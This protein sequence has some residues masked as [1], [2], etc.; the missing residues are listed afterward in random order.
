LNHAPVLDT[1][2]SSTLPPVNQSAGENPGSLIAT[3]AGNRITDADSTAQRGIAVIRADN[4]FGNWQFSTDNGVTWLAVADT[5]IGGASVWSS[6]LLLADAQTRIR[7]VPLAGWHGTAEMNYRAWDQ[8]DGRANGGLSATG[9]TGGTSPFSTATESV[10]VSVVPPVGLSSEVV[11]EHA[12]LG[13]VVGSLFM[14]GNSASGSTYRLVSGPGDTG[15]RLFTIVGNQLRTAS[16]TFDYST[17]PWTYTFRVQATA[18]GGTTTEQVVR[19]YVANDNQAPT[20]ILLS[21]ATLAESSPAGTTVATLGV[22]DPDT[23]DRFSY[24][25]VSGAGSDDNASFVIRN[26]LLTSNVSFDH[27]R[28]DTYR[29]RVRATDQG[30]LWVEQAFVLTVL[31]NGPTTNLTPYRVFTWNYPEQESSYVLHTWNDGIDPGA[32]NTYWRRP[33]LAAKAFLAFPA[34][35]RALLVQPADLLPDGTAITSH[36]ADAIYDPAQDADAGAVAYWGPW[37]SHG[38]QAA[39]E[40]VTHYFQTLK[41]GGL[42]SL[43][44]LMLDWEGYSLSFW[45]AVASPAGRIRAIRADPRYAEFAAQFEAAFPEMFPPGEHFDLNVFWAD[46][47]WRLQGQQGLQALYYWSSFMQSWYDRALNDAIYEAARSVF[48]GVVCGNFGVSGSSVA[49]AVQ[50][51][52][53]WPQMAINGMWADITAP[54]LYDD[55]GRLGLGEV[56]NDPYRNF[57]LIVNATRS[58][59]RQYPNLPVIPWLA[60]RSYTAGN[61]S[62]VPVANTDYWQEMLIHTM[63]STGSTNAFCFNST[64]VSTTGTHWTYDADV[65]AFESVL[66]SLEQLAPRGFYRDHPLDLL[67]YADGFSVSYATTDT[68]RIVG[69]VTFNSATSRATFRVGSLSLTVDRGAGIPA[70]D[71]LP[72]GQFFVIDPPAAVG[73]TYHLAQGSTLVISAAG[74]LANDADPAGRPLQAAIVSHPAHGALSLAADGSFTYTPNAGFWGSD[75]FTYQATNGAA[76]SPAVPV[77]VAVRPQLRLAMA[78]PSDGF[79]GVPGQPRTFTLSILDGGASGQI[80]PFNYRIRWGD[81]SEQVVAGDAT[82]VSHAFVSSGSFTPWVVAESVDGPLSEAMAGPR[83]VITALENQGPNLAVGGAANAD[84]FRLAQLATPGSFSVSVNASSYGTRAVSGAGRILVFGDANDRLTIT[85]TSRVDSFLLTTDAV[86][87]NGV[88]VQVLGGQS[89]VLDGYA[90]TDTLVG[91]D[92]NNT[93]QLTGSLS[94]TLNSLIAFKGIEN[95]SGGSRDDRFQLAGTSTGIRIDG[96]EGNNTLDYGAV[97]AAIAINVGTSTANLITRFYNIQAFVGGLNGRS[98]L[99]SGAGTNTWILDGPG[100]GSLNGAR[101]SGF[102]DLIG[103]TGSDTISVRNAGRL[104]GTVDGGGGADVLDYSLYTRGGV[105]IDLR[106]GTASAIAQARNIRVVVGTS[107]ADTLIAGS[108][109][110]VLIGDAGDDTLTGGSAR[111]LLIG[112]QGD[113]RLTAT[114]GETILFGGRT[115]YYNEETK[116]LDVSAIDTILQQWGKAVAYASRIASLWPTWVNAT[117]FLAERNARD[118]LFGGAAQDWYLT[119]AGNTAPTAKSNETVTFL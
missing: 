38:L 21:A 80:A 106:A 45:P 64:L 118:Q 16:T 105:R 2:G 113:D 7:F 115:V 117:T 97:N 10:T 55:I 110:T 36:P 34:G 56:W 50:Q 83:L 14:D 102:R 85:G 119:P 37:F 5:Y 84:E 53:N 3:I 18:P 88:T 57:Q 87:L 59:V 58:S 43:D 109:P 6:R 46:G 15:N 72:L 1:S 25:L 78:G 61:P 99:R 92:R 41:D 104:E 81:G 24:Q 116:V 94:G 44:A 73:D 27:H 62:I 40:Q 29:I 48:P 79:Q 17:G 32:G 13:T 23:Y 47:D 19:V 65:P 68:G 49:D 69:R 107:A 90:G 30:G 33:D 114:T 66:S 100:A 67:S 12:P 74:V 103:G 31:A 8:T 112:G 70:G 42:T 51:G 77:Q 111:S 4:T 9:E 86:A 39:R 98:T 20:E 93:W 28:Q 101:F 96:R 89:L 60:N 11:P 108:Q 71:P 91:P 76:F 82:S 63:L 75:R 95:V 54:A 52:I 22:E 26:D 35:Q